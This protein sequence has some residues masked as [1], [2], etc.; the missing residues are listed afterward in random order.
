MSWGFVKHV[1]ETAPGCELKEE[2]HRM[3][4]MMNYNKTRA[5]KLNTTCENIE[6]L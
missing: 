1:E 5:E 4:L 6:K 3:S 2:T